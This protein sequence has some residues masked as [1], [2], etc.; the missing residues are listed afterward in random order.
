[1]WIRSAATFDSTY[2]KEETERPGRMNGGKR[3]SED[4]S[5][6]ASKRA[7]ESRW[8]IEHTWDLRGSEDG[9]WGKEREERADAPAGAG[10]HRAWVGWGG[11]RK[12]ENHEGHVYCVREQNGCGTGLWQALAGWAV[13]FWLWF[14]WRCGLV[15]NSA[16][17]G[18]YATSEPAAVAHAI[19][20]C[21]SPSPFLF[22][23]SCR[24]A[25]CLQLGS[26][27]RALRAA[28]SKATRAQNLVVCGADLLHS[29][30]GTSNGSRRRIS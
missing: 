16:A 6:R 5:E 28:R 13:G 15:M 3:A 1:M 30:I 12:R 21:I 17:R 19:A 27:K 26:L 7:S 24:G 22:Y 8:A 29:G 10:G 9:P 25:R 4:S 2:M 20:T 18:P 14:R 23:L 11:G